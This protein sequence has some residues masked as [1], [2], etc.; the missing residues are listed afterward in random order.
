MTL[1]GRRRCNGECFGDALTLSLLEVD[2][3]AWSHFFCYFF[4][5]RLKVDK[6]HDMFRLLI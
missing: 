5:L 1:F 6:G 4:F 3:Q 2:P